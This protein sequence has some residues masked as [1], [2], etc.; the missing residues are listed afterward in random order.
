MTPTSGRTRRRKSMPT[1]DDS[2]SNEGRST[3]DRSLQNIQYEWSV[4]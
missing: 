4:V 1:F 2:G 3:S